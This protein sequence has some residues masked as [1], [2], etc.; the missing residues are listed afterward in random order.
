MLASLVIGVTACTGYLDDLGA[1]PIGGGAGDTFDGDGAGAEPGTSDTPP[2]TPEGAGL[3][4]LRRLSKIEYAHTIESL[5]GEGVATGVDLPEDP[6]G[7][8]SF[9]SPTVVGS[10]ELDRFEQAANDLAK[11]QAEKVRELAPCAAGTSDAACAQAFIASFGGRAF[12]RPVTDAE[13]NA[14][15]ELYQ[16]LR[17]APIG[18][19]YD[20]GISTLFTAMLQSPAFLYHWELGS[21][22][23]IMEGKLVRLTGYEMASR[24]SYFLW[25]TMPDAELLS[26]A[27]SGLLDSPEG[28]SAQVK[29]M[30]KSPLASRVA[31][32]MV[33]QW[34]SIDKL[35]GLV[36]DPSVGDLTPEL[37]AAMK[38]ELELFATDTL[39]TRGSF[40]DLL[41][42]DQGFV[43][44]SLASLYGLDG[45]FG[46]DLV[47][48]TLPAERGGVFS[49]SA[50]LAIEALPQES[51]PV[52]RGKLVT[53]R[54]LCRTVP[55]PPVGL[56]VTPP[57]VPEGLTTREAYAQHATDP[58]CS[59][60]H[61]YMDPLGFAFENFDAMGRFRTTEAGQNIDA[62]GRVTLLDGTDRTF[63]GHDEL[64]TAIAD[65]DEG[66]LC[67]IE[68][69]TR[70]GLGRE[71]G[72]F[73]EPTKQEIASELGDAVLDLN[74]LLPAL[75]SSKS[76]RYRIAAEGEEIK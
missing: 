57:E 5:L 14:L 49:L 54:L 4:P 61:K 50:F 51:S 10:V 63:D 21:D 70:Y 64:M 6:I 20:E 35:E 30:L 43:D 53:N 40:K 29:R 1:S 47:A 18:A 67:L 3:M 66:R 73:D 68:Q 39:L 62:S 65:S 12:R 24:L 23:P 48:T 38:R 9:A 75:A 33:G 28:V 59:G 74:Q 36:K 52:R 58:S 31:S 45:T 41:T 17:A 34:V 25:S 56:D 32:G 16:A 22:A 13:A 8:S 27:G 44:A 42:S 72:E 46:G 11:S 76:F 26:A 19:T 37:K 60:C 69:L 7:A 2:G 71:T 55:P 15:L